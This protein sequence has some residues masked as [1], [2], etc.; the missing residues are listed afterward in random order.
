VTY[1]ALREWDDKA[2]ASK[3]NDDHGYVKSLFAPESTDKVA[4][5]LLCNVRRLRADLKAHT[6][7]KEEAIFTRMRYLETETREKLPTPLPAAL[8]RA[9]LF[10]AALR[11]Q[12]AAFAGSAVSSARE[13]WRTLFHHGLRCL[14]GI[15]GTKH[16]LD[17]T[18]SIAERFG[19][20]EAGCRSSPPWL[21]A[22]QR[23]NSEPCAE[24]TSARSEAP[25]RRTTL[26]TKPLRRRQLRR[27][28]HRRG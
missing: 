1:L 23:E 22:S 26:F 15:P 2:D 24:R 10:I 7:E 12:P 21:C 27:S 25:H 6:R 28:G 17:R 9:A 16:C 13:A 11:V 8:G 14:V 5:A 19:Q 4:P 20:G 18:V 3:L